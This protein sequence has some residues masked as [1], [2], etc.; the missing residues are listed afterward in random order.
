MHLKEKICKL[1]GVL[2]YRID[3]DLHKHKLAIEANELGH[4]DRNLSQRQIT[5]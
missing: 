1:N 4:V 3:L 2:G 5:Q